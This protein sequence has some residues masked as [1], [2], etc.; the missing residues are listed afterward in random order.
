MRLFPNHAI[1]LVTEKNMNY[2]PVIYN[3]LLP[4]EVTLQLFFKL[5]YYP[6]QNTPKISPA[7]KKTGRSTIYIIT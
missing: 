4:Q 2:Y 3:L 5:F 7:H 6:L 1:I